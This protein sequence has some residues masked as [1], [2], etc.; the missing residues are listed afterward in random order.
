[1]SQ[2]PDIRPGLLFLFTAWLWSHVPRVTLRSV[3]GEDEEI[4]DEDT[5]IQGTEHGNAYAVVI[6]VIAII[7]VFMVAVGFMKGVP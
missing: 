3:D 2:R 5:S 7:V 4:E 1:M 6:L